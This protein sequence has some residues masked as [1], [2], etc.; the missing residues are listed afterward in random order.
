MKFSKRNKLPFAP[1]VVNKSTMWRAKEIQQC[2]KLKIEKFMQKEIKL[3]VKQSFIFN[4]CYLILQQIEQISQTKQIV[5]H[6]I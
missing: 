4:I 3:L 1:F 6:N 2:L 5:Q